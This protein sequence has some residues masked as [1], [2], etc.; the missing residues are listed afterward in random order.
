MRKVFL[1]LS[2]ILASCPIVA[3]SNIQLS[4]T[5]STSN[6]PQVCKFSLTHYSGKFNGD[7]DTA[8]FKVGLSC[9]Q[10]TKVYATVELYVEGNLVTTMVVGI[11][12]GQTYSDLVSF[13]MDITYKGKTY[14]LS[15][16]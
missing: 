16:Q 5:A 1:A 8:D 2:V 10:A 6:N 14:E 4:T 13:N 3:A 7:G 15:V 11:E 12:A 9:P